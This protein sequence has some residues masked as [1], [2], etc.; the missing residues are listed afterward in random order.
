MKTI[1]ILNHYAGNNEV[2]LEY[3]HFLIAKELKKQG[4]DVVIIASSYTHL[5]DKPIEIEDNYLYEKYED[6]SYVWIKTPKYV[7]NGLSRFKNMLAYSINLQRYYRELNISKPDF[8]L[9]SS[10]HPFSILNGYNISKYYNAKF[11]FEE[12]DLW[13]MSI[14][15]LTGMKKYHPISLLIQWLEDLAY[16][17]AD[18]I[19]SPLINLEKNINLRNINHKDFLFLPNGIL[20]DDIDSMLNKNIDV[21]SYIEKHKLLVG[22][23]GTVGISNCVDTLVYVANELRDEDIGF[24]I[25]GDGEEYKKL[26]KYVEENNLSNVYMIGRKDK[27]TTL[28]ILNK[29]DILYNAVPKNKLYEFGLSAIKVPEYMYLG[30]YI[31][32][33][34]DIK[35]DIVE[36]A[37]CGS[38][39]KPQNIDALVYEIKLLSNYDKKKLEKFGKRAKE[40]VENNLSY[41][42]LVQKLIK[43][44]EDIKT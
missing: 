27:E 31:I 42:V 44:L 21:D 40:F 17:K 7:G 37:R 34:V 20:L 3:R 39:I 1:W 43:K 10:P 25:I 5:L 36:V 12:R 24:I 32:N 23:G 11:I 33:A 26:V 30:K 2:G 38:T 35:N 13:P 6:I 14:I 8:V 28:S 15:E 29:C 22:F 18:L 9:S 41:D 4:Y 19:V 16:K